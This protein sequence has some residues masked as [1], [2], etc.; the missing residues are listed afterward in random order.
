M[1]KPLYAIALALF[2]AGAVHA[3]SPTASSLHGVWMAATGMEGI[4]KFAPL[5]KVTL[6]PLG[7]APLSG[8]FAVSKGWLEIKPDD[9][10]PA[11]TMGIACE[12]KDTCTLT[13]QDGTTQR[14]QRVKPERVVKPST[15]STVK[16]KP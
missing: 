12:A 8:K 11:A 15:K 9:G 1:L 13:Y 14:F 6:I 7:S 3:S 16:E 2:M 5:D 4:M 10:R